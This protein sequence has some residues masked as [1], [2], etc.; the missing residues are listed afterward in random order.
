MEE[1]PRTTYMGWERASIFSKH[2][3]LPAS[4]HV[5]QP[6]SFPNPV[7]WAS[8]HRNDESLTSFPALFPSLGNGGWRRGGC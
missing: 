6:R 5:N 7:L 1:M 4:P 3:H 2:V 8:S